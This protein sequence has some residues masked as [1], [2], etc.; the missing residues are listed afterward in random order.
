MK[1]ESLVVSLLMTASCLPLSA[2]ADFL[3]TARNF[4]VLGGSTVTNTGA[5]IINGDLGVWPGTAITGIPPAVVNGTIHAN[6]GVAQQ[7]QSDVAAGYNA[8]ALL[9]PTM[10]L[11]G[12][13]MGGMTLT[14]G[15]YFFSTSAQLTG[16]ITLDGGGNPDA[17]FVFQIGST[18]TTASAAR[19]NLIN[20]A[21]GCNIYWQVGSSATLGTATEFNGNI[22]AMAS[23]TL[24]TGATILDG[25]TLA[26]SG[27]VTLDSNF[28]TADCIPAPGC[29]ALLG[30][31][32][33]ILNKRRRP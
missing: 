18:L 29:V 26:R 15:V 9:A 30:S 8:L 33:L 4:A 7:A 16:V 28:V 31:A 19:V 5:S 23:I 12:A 32:C 2:S 21:D 25:R 22:F 27:A 17:Q 6:D 24:N 14:T 13:D 3:G 10:N 20:G 1:R 11:T